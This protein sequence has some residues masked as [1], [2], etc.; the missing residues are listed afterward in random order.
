MDVS[1]SPEPIHSNRPPYRPPIGLPAAPEDRW[2]GPLVSVLLHTAVIALLAL[3]AIID[4]PIF[5]EEQEGAGGPGPAGGGGGGSGGTGGALRPVEERIRYIEVAPEP[6]LVAPV[7]TPIVPPVVPPVVP[8]PVVPPPVIPPPEPVPVPP[9]PVVEPPPPPVVPEVKTDPAPP[10]A[11]TPPA[12]LVAGTGG[13][14]GNDG[15]QGAGPGS[16]GGVGSGI[17]TGRGSGVGPGTGGG[18]GNIHTPSAIQVF[19]PPLPVPDRIK[20][21][22]IVA[23]FDVDEKGNVIKF[24][25]NESKDRE[26]NRKLRALL[27]EVRFRPATTLD[28]VPIRATAVLRFDAY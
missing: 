10:A 22:H 5:L 14:S 20:P 17:G 6:A 3:P 24:D 19:I 25:F 15:S 8:P 12:S 21:Y 11:I 13:G 4:S 18:A 7:E 23:T 27:K 28:G 1:R 2:R 9:E 26:Y 16:G